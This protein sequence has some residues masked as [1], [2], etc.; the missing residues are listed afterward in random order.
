VKFKLDE[1]LGTRTQQLFQAAAHDAATVGGQELTG[2][3]DQH[4]YDVCRAESRCLVTLDLDFSD[5]RRFPPDAATGIVVIRL[6]ANPTLP[7]LES[8]VR[9]F[10][11]AL[12]EDPLT[13]RLWIV[14]PDRIRIHQTDSETD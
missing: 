9:E 14:E 5:V 11:A 13:G 7:V 6:P 12:T 4:L 8:L 1:N 3:T 2:C 10:L